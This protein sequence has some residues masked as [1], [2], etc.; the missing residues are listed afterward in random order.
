MT[1][2]Q[3]TVQSPALF[4]PPS[5]VIT[6]QTW[7]N[8]SLSHGKQMMSDIPSSAR[9]PI[10][11]RVT[12]RQLLS[13]NEPLRANPRFVAVRHQIGPPLFVR[14]NRSTK[15]V[16]GARARRTQRWHNRKQVAA[17]SKPPRRDSPRQRHPSLHQHSLPSLRCHQYATE[18]HRIVYLSGAKR[19]HN[20]GDNLQ[21][22]RCGHSR[23]HP[24]P[25]A[26]HRINIPR[27]QQ[28]IGVGGH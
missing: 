11:H 14:H 25:G 28:F 8:I 22:G 12:S 9:L 20:V 2:Q 7:R 13:T 15:E 5:T 19:N 26:G 24:P 10:T 18:E 21:H 17:Q 1:R 27:R 23:R 16:D 4:Y 6:N 3:G